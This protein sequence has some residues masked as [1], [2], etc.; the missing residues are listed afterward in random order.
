MSHP[1]HKNCAAAVL[2]GLAVL[3]LAFSAFAQ[4]GRT[5]S[6]AKILGAADQTKAD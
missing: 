5:L 4:S 3:L 6:S 2:A 1:S